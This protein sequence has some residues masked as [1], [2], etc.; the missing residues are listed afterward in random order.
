[1]GLRSRC[2]GYPDRTISNL[3]SG[4]PG[5]KR[6]PLGA[7]RR[8]RLRG[9]GSA[10]G[11][12]DME[13]SKKQKRGPDTFCKTVMKAF[14]AKAQGG[15][16]EGQGGRGGAGQRCGPAGISSSTSGAGRLGL[17]D[18]IVDARNTATC[19]IDG[20]NQRSLCVEQS[21]ALAGRLGVMGRVRGHFGEST[22]TTLPFVFALADRVA[23]FR[24]RCSGHRTPRSRRAGAHGRRRAELGGGRRGGRARA[25]RLLGGRAPVGPGAGH[26]DHARHDG[27]VPPLRLRLPGGGERAQAGAASAAFEG[28]D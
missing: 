5:R 28:E 20:R 25:P 17:S 12:A 15:R 7:A 6:S 22:D 2:Q 21:S 11:L 1:M 16:E 13:Y 9:R 26:G 14:E 8:S 19:A 3:A 4:R 18:R 24:R 23:S 10:A 27:Q